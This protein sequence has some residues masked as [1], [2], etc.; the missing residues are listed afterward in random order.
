MTHMTPDQARVELAV[1]AHPDDPGRF[2]EVGIRALEA[3]AA[4]TLEYGVADANG[5]IEWFPVDATFGT[6][7]DARRDAVHYAASDQFFRLVC[8]RVSQPWDSEGVRPT[9][10][11]EAEMD[12][13]WRLLRDHNAEAWHVL[14]E[15]QHARAKGRKTIRIDDLLGGTDE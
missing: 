6:A 12:E 2:F 15:V 7:E 13:Q 1:I 4:D 9:R 10:Q 5:D 14:D 8:R 11:H 3:L